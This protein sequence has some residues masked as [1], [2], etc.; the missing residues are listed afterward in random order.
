VLVGSD[1]THKLWHSVGS[2]SL[3]R[4]TVEASAMLKMI[5]GVDQSSS[6]PVIRCLMR[7]FK[8]LVPRAEIGQCGVNGRPDRLYLVGRKSSL[9]AYFEDR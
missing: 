4:L 6:I 2:S 3:L 9:M 5:G 7:S 1:D 8:R